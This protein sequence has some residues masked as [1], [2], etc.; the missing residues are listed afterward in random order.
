MAQAQIKSSSQSTE[1]DS[2]ASTEKSEPNQGLLQHN[3]ELQRQLDDEASTLDTQFNEILGLYRRLHIEL[4]DDGRSD[5]I[6]ALFEDHRLGMRL[7]GFELVNRDLSSNT[8]LKP[9]VS[10][11]AKMMLGDSHATVRAKSAQLI[12]RLV[13]PDAMIV[14]VESLQN[15]LDPVAAEPMLL[16]VARWPSLESVDSVLR[17][18][19]A[20]DSPFDAAC[21]AA[22]SLEQS[23]LWDIQR[24]HPLLLEKL[25]STSPDALGEDGMKLIARIGDASDLEQLVSLLLA[26]DPIQQQWAAN[27]LVETP[28]SVEVLVQ[29]A[30]EN[31]FLFKAASDAMI[32]HRATPEGLRRLV[33]L[34]YP[35]AESR[36]DAIMRMGLELED[37]RLG[38]AVRLSGLD[39]TLSIMLLNRLL[40]SDLKTITPRIA[41]GIILLAQIELDEHRPDRAFEAAI[42][43]KDVG[44]DP[45]DR[46]RADLIQSS[47]LI[48][49]GKLDE[50][51]ALNTDPELWYS[52]LI[53]APPG[54]LRER[55]AVFM[56]SHLNEILSAQ[57]ILDIEQAGGIESPSE[58]SDAEPG[59]DNPS[60]ESTQP[61]QP[62]DDG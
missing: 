8:V 3:N 48:Q 61:A 1:D 6:V 39:P 11:A 4:D 19:L 22:W 51:I 15:E 13:P 28:R 31:E 18:F 2:G 37:D 5:L 24:H 46:L 52:M 7:L 58:P 26:Q 50:A 42:T 40:N 20:P 33:T 12:T 9:A 14:L 27:A 23:Q 34:P 55:I 32:R 45:A 57:Q 59:V 41:K 54:A 44:L 56:L 35:N 17:W 36:N 49:L 30:E 38:E 25:R 29:A 53:S 62:S 21:A 60:T 43:L 16:G 47:A 10:E